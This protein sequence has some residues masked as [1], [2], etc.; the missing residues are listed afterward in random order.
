MTIQYGH[1][2]SL[3]HVCWKSRW[4]VTMNQDLTCYMLHRGFSL[5]GAINAVF[6]TQFYCNWD[7]SVHTLV[8]GKDQKLWVD[9][10][11]T[12]HSTDQLNEILNFKTNKIFLHDH[13]W[14][15]HSV[16]TVMLRLPNKWQAYFSTSSLILF[17]QLL[18]IIPM[19][20]VFLTTFKLSI[21]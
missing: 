2:D 16:I 3:L 21:N 1:R 11:F 14:Y 13:L 20:T 6:G 18:S 17:T 19:P 8:A 15:V 5:T 4:T 12:T 9:E 10:H 7:S